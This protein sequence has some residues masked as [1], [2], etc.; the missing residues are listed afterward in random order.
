MAPNTIQ[1]E[2]ATENEIIQHCSR[3]NPNREIVSELDGGLSVIKISEDAVIKCGLGVNEFEA[4]NQKLAYE[5]LNPTIIRVPRVYRFFVCGVNGYLIMEYIK[6]RLLSTLGPDAYLERMA[7]VLKHF[8]SV[9]RSRPGPLHESLAFGQLWLDYDPIAP[10]SIELIENY[11][12]TR[13]LKK[14]THI[15]LA[16]YPLV[17]CHLDIAPRN[18]LVLDD[19][20]L[21]LL[22]WHSAGFYPRLFERTTLRINVRNNYDWNA[23]LLGLLDDLDEEEE[24]QA[25]L[26]QRAYNL[27]Q[28]YMYRTQKFKP[29]PPPRMEIIPN[30]RNQREQMSERF[31]REDV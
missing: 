18:I 2:T 24:L 16:G 26:L 28:K 10:T 27:G 11:F 5:I 9:Q 1:W 30:R 25:Q 23:N 12:N 17:L 29:A 14:S 21:C 8:E 13:Q 19:D 15:K 3:D 20:S 31:G 6:G 4:A 22:D 7:N